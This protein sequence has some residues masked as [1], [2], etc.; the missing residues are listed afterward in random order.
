MMLVGYD[1]NALLAIFF[2]PE[3][4]PLIS[5]HLQQTTVLQ[6]VIEQNI[7]WWVIII[8]RTI[9]IPIASAIQPVIS[10]LQ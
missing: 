2:R 9:L 7:I 8:S 5:Y 4:W 10:V 3:I 6:H 1:F